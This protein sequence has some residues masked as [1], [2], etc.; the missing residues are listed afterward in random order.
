MTLFGSTIAFAF[1]FGFGGALS[2]VPSITVN[3][4]FLLFSSHGATYNEGG[5]MIDALR[6]RAV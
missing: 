1:A 6:A 4:V 3:V 5:A 2:F